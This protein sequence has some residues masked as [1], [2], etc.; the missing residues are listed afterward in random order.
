[1]S[2]VAT[3][4]GRLEKLV[5]SDCVQFSE[6]LLRDY[7]ISGRSPA[8]VLKPSS[9]GEVAEIVR[10][11]G[12]EKLALVACGSR[13]KLEL[14]MPPQRYDL[15]L[16]MTGLRQM[17]H[18][19]PGDLTVSVDAGIPLSELAKTLAANHQFLPLAVPCGETATAGG[20]IA[21]GIDSA[22]RLQYGTARDFLIG[23]EFVDGTG[24]L[25][26]S[27]GRVVKNVTGYDLHKLLIGSLGTLGVITRLNFR[28]FPLPES[29]GVFLAAFPLLDGALN[30]RACLLKSGLPFSNVE[31]FDVAFAG[32]LAE[33]L[34]QSGIA[35]EE[36]LAAGG[37][38]VYASFA[39]NSAVIQRIQRELRERSAQ[40]EA[41]RSQALD[42][43]SSESLS[44]SLRDAFDWLRHATSNV[45]LLRLT[46]PQFT[47]VDIVE[48]QHLAN[49]PPLSTA[50]VLRACNVAYL[51][52][53]SDGEGDQTDTLREQCVAELFSRAEAK[54]GGTTIL[55]A[56]HQLKDRVSAWGTKR[57]DFPLMQRVKQAFDPQ[58][59]FAP[60]RFL[61][62]I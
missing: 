14:G 56:S 43:K 23:A 36:S 11:A 1:M 32:R 21:S 54:K 38:Q 24:R 6:A 27:G 52:L 39:G 19:D 22:L 55:H 51:T 13:S 29:R 3:L 46:L 41:L 40:A 58:N 47:S 50:F 31:F 8:A 25:C 45:T 49:H 7:A 5:G 10:F 53:I 59:I 35:V 26:K 9:A 17:A 62:G 16:D 12:A 48:L 33:N 28:T 42:E 4:C 30:Y 44:K 37:W 57:A 60:G 15:A 61:G 2:S 34:N 20:A 18:Y